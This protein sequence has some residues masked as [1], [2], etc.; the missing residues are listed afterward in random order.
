MLGFGL[1]LLI[2]SFLASFI[3]FLEAR[4]PHLESSKMKLFLHIGGELEISDGV[5][6]WRVQNTIEVQK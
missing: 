4:F 2:I 1:L 5:A 6:K 3:T